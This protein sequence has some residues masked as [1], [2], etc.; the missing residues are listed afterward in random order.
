MEYARFE[1]PAFRTPYSL[2]G[3]CRCQI[4]S[5]KDARWVDIGTDWKQIS[6]TECADRHPPENV[7]DVEAPPELDTVISAD[8]SIEQLGKELRELKRR[9]VDAIIKILSD[10]GIEPGITIY[11]R[12]TPYVVTRKYTDMRSEVYVEM[13]PAKKDG[14]A[15]KINKTEL[16]WTDAIRM[17][18]MQRAD[19]EAY[20]LL[21][22]EHE[23]EIRKR[24][25]MKINQD[26]L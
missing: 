16:K 26:D 3:F 10:E 20:M 24:R 7:S 19:L 25:T 14:S 2:C 13:T 1:D 15:S 23:E 5:R 9:R 18:R 21:M 22:K 4:D 6:C 11:F 12:Y 17:W 8:E